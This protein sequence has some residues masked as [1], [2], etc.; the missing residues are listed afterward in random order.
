MLDQW[1]STIK[2][3]LTWEQFQ[4]LPQNRAYKYEYVDGTAW[5]SPRPKSYH[6]LLGLRRFSASIRM[7]TDEQVM[8]QPLC[9][10]DWDDLPRPFA[11]AFQRVQPFASLDDEARSRAAQD[12]L[13]RTRNGE[14]GPLID[15]ACFI[16]VRSEDGAPVGAILVTLMPAGD[17]TDWRSF[18][19]TSPPP[20]DVAE[21]GQARPHLTWIFISPWY[22]GHGVGTALPDASVRELLRLGY[23]ELAST[24]LLGNES[25]TLWHWRMGFQLLPYLGSM[26]LIREQVRRDWDERT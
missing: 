3:P 15:T 26:R 7:A 8:V 17:L 22:G 24:F 9:V 14:E 5:L 16:A 12:C 20:S 2:L 25:S 1:F 13:L 21:P 10:E 18:R 19:W 4:Q 23:T 6:A 11:G